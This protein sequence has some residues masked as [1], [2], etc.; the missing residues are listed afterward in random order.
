MCSLSLGIVFTFASSSYKSMLQKCFNLNYI[1]ENP[2]CTNTQSQKNSLPLLS[3]EADAPISRNVVIRPP[4]APRSTG[5]IPIAQISASR[6][7]SS[8][9]V[10]KP[11]SHSSSASSLTK[12]S[13][14]PLVRFPP[15]HLLHPAPVLLTEP[16]SII[17]TNRGSVP[18][19]RSNKQPDKNLVVWQASSGDDRSLSWKE[20]SPVCPT[21]ANAVPV[22]SAASNA[23]DPAVTS[24]PPPAKVARISQPSSVHLPAS[25]AS[26]APSCE[27]IEEDSPLEWS[28]S[29]ALIANSD[30]TGLP[31]HPTRKELERAMQI[32]FHRIKA[33]H[34]FHHPHVNYVKVHMHFFA[35]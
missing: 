26:S 4:I 18:S 8:V 30:G 16:T 33:L 6:P 19:V 5:V 9:A 3:S 23:P 1:N 20:L 25:V 24:A 17:T 29:D 32:F 7:I 13:L 14:C 12:I 21:P 34:K 2:K 10:L 11:G 27:L 31:E 35:Q 28:A 22:S 15:G